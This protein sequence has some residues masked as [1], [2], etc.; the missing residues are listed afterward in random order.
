M[1]GLPYYKAYPRDFIEGT[2]GMPFELK[3]AYRILLDLIYMQGGKLPDDARYISGLLGCSVKK[4]NTLRSG[5]LETGKVVLISEFLT[6][7]RAVSE[8]ETLAKYQRKQS[9]NASSS[10][11]NKDLPKPPLSHT[12]TDTDTVDTSLRSVAAQAPSKRKIGSRLPVDWQLPIAWGQWA[13]DEVRGSDVDL[14]RS[15]ADQFRDYWISKSGSGA[16]KMDW[17]ATWRNWMRRA[18][19][20][21]KPRQQNL[22][23]LALVD[24]QLREEIENGRN[25]SAEGIGSE[26]LPRLSFGGQ[27]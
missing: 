9:E 21:A 27:R 14:I 2:I 12:D 26:S 6:N 23:G 10:S 4:W 17:E 13:L 5:L 8:V 20:A 19:S 7:H 24:Q 16:T 22:K 1:N 15:Q 3:G 18:A 25:S 11:K